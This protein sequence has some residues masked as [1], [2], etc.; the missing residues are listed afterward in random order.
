[1][2]NKC[3]VI[4][5]QVRAKNAMLEGGVPFNRVHGT[6]VFEYSLLNPKFNQIFNDAMFNYSN[7]VIKEVLDSYQGFPRLNLVVD[8]GGGLGHTI[9]AIKSKHPHTKDINFGLPHVIN[10]APNISGNE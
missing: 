3:F 5:M 4:L 8:V 9:K 1:M 7:M 2:R 10:K 6:N